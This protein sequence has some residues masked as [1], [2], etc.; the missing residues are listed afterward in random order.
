MKK[1]LSIILVVVLAAL[2]GCS[3]SGSGEETKTVKLGIS[4]SDTRVWDFISKKAEKEGI[5][6]EIVKF[7]DYVQPNMAL[8]EGE[9]DANSFQTV[10]YFN[11]FKKEHNLDLSAVGTTVLAPM[12]LFSNKVKSP[13]EIGKGDEIA[14]P[15]DV[16]NLGRALLLLQKAG[17]IQLKE[18]FDGKGGLENITEDNG[19]KITPVTAAQTPRALDDVAASI[20]NNG[21]A[22]DAGLNPKEDPIFREDKTAVPYVNIIASQ[23]DRKNDKTLKRLVEIYQSKSVSDFIKK[24]YKGATIPTKLP[25][26][27]IENL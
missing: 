26:K 17:L 25:V 24:T 9:I 12:G 21:I 11:E 1:L 4:G 7:S 23:S 22:V 13:K 20:I 16:T 2:A 5:K 6:I 10:A 19:I 27:E 14:V 15:N 3:S 18:G 8:A